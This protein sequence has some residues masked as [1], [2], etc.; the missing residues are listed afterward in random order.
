MVDARRGGFRGYFR[1]DW[2]DAARRFMTHGG[3]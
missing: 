2:D 1:R 3:Q